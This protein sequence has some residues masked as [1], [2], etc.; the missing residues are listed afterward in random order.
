M[1][2]PKSKEDAAVRGTSETWR[3][4]LA[5][6]A[7][8]ERAYTDETFRYF[9]SLERQRAERSGRAV[10]LLLVG[11]KSDADSGEEIP[12]VFVEKLFS[13]LSLC[14]R[15]VDFIGWYRSGRVMGA[16]LAQGA[17]SPALEASDQIAHRVTKTLRECLP[18][19]LAGRLQV[20]VLQARQAVQR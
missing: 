9:L 4:E 11:L 8:H 20:R 10:L 7:S 2:I 13:G 6:E 3:G 14:V 5:L 19:H 18:A 17:G 16:V 1:T 15:D 12:S